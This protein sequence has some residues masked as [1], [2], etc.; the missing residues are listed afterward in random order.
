AALSIED[1]YKKMAAIHPKGSWLLT[2]LLFVIIGWSGLR[3][4]SVF[5]LF[6]NDARIAAGRYIQRLP[7]KVS[8]ETTLYPPYIDRNTFHRVHDYP[9][10]FPKYPGHLPPESKITYNQAEIGLE[11]R[12][13]DYLIVDSFTYQRFENPYIC[14]SVA[15][16]CAFFQR[17][18]RGET[19][20]QLI[21]EFKYTLPCFLPQ[22]QAEFI[23]PI[24]LIYRN[25]GK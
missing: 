16:E 21:A 5:L 11:A 20:Y 22:I 8:I 7:H 4:I 2:I 14:Q 10:F 24:I 17:L 12:H 3:V 15:I 6:Q 1:I 19:Q 13:P 9:I 23:N 25:A 18:L